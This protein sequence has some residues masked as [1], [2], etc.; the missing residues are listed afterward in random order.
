MKNIKGK[1]VRVILHIGAD[2]DA[3]ER[4]GDIWRVISVGQFT[5]MLEC[6]ETI[7]T[8]SVNDIKEFELDNNEIVLMRNIKRKLKYPN[9]LY[10]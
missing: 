2:R 1:T 9:F 3:I 6:G 7:W 4:Y 10:Q 8:P 5:A